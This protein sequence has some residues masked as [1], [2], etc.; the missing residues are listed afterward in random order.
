MEEEGVVA[1]KLEQRHRCAMEEDH[2]PLPDTV[3]PT[4]WSLV[5]DA[6]DGGALTA[7]GFSYPRR[8]VCVSPAAGDEEDIGKMDGGGVECPPV[9]GGQQ[10]VRGDG[11]TPAER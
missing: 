8:T 5:A 11:D 2:G 6:R 7:A 4:H 1:V 9:F 3:E 10:R